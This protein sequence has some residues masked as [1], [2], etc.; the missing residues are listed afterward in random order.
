[1]IAMSSL[2]E[3]LDHFGM[4]SHVMSCAEAHILACSECSRPLRLT[5]VLPSIL[6]EIGI[7]T[8]VFE[9][10]GCRASFTRTLRRS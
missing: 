5:R 9:C 7:E 10:T 6:R 4:T 3:Q 8:A 2:S 1:M